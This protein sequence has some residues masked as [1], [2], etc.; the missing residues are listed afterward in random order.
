[1]TLPALPVRFDYLRA[2]GR[3][4]AFA[5]LKMELDA[6]GLSDE[7][8]AMQRGSAVHALL[9][10]TAKVTSYP[11]AVRRGKEWDAFQA[12]NG[13]ALILTKAEHDKAAA[14]AEAV[15]RHK[16]AVR[17]LE[18]TR[19]KTINF[20][21][22]GRDC[23]C[24]PDV[25]VYDSRAVELKTT[26]SADPVRFQSHALR[27]GYHG[28]LSWQLN[29]IKAAGLGQPK[30]AYIVAVE[31]SPPYP[32][33]VLRLTSRALEQGER[34]WRLWFERFQVCE[35]SGYW[36]AYAESV[37]DLDVPD[38]VELTFSDEALEAAGAPPF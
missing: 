31:S 13:G 14:M 7:T 3:C 4:P 27:L 16:E 22:N 38:D 20:K 37:V 33:T 17:L 12:E 32:V 36:P 6:Q 19:E 11:G 9:F 30:E 23:R 25:A 2:V 21:I 29:A 34:L 35:Q 1:M 8:A 15:R 28:Q 10:E 24:T 18:G 5:K 26:F